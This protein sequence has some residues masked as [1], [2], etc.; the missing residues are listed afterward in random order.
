[1]VGRKWR[2]AVPPVLCAALCP[3]EARR[4]CAAALGRGLGRKGVV[5]FSSRAGAQASLGEENQ[6]PHMLEPVQE[7]SE[8]R[9]TGRKKVEI[10]EF[11]TRLYPTHD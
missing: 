11:F 9:V 5:S 10:S 8:F 3:Q 7:H 6:A 1:M 2:S 4:L